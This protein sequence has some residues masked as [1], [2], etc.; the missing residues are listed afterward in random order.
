[1]AALAEIS[2]AQKIA[3]K[4]FCLLLFL[5]VLYGCGAETA[6]TA[7]TGASIKA[8]EVEEAK[9]TEERTRQ[10]LDQALQQA[11]KRREEK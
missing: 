7:A 4:R 9:K 6:T 3:V 1:M 8:R 11:E 5:A 10:K 2:R